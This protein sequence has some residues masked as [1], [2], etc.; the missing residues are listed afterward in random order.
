MRTTTIVSVTADRQLEIPLE[1]QANLNPGDEYM[2]WTTGD[3]ILFKK[4]QKPLTYSSLLQRIEGL[5]IDSDEMSL[6][7][8]SNLIKAIRH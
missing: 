4:I 7:E 6:E 5:G 3:S 8:I 1:I 2:I